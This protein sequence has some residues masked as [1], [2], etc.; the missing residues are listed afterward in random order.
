MTLIRWEI[1]ENLFLPRI[2]YYTEHFSNEDIRSGFPKS[3]FSCRKTH[4]RKKIIEL[5]CNPACGG[6]VVHLV[7]GRR[8][9]VDVPGRTYV[10]PW[11]TR[12]DNNGGKTRGNGLF[13][14]SGVLPRL[15]LQGSQVRHSCFPVVFGRTHVQA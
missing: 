2:R 15:G 11:S 7:G 6:L 8:V 14:D 10:V 9:K 3:Q 12:T 13:K 5:V 4:E 1:P